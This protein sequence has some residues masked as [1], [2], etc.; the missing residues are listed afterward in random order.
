MTDQDEHYKAH[1]EQ[2]WER[3][4]S[5]LLFL[6]LIIVSFGYWVLP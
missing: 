1:S 5:S 3:E 4:I 6:G 2:N